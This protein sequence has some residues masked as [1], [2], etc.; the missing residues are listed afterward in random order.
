MTFDTC[1]PWFSSKITSQ[2]HFMLA[3]KSLRR[4]CWRLKANSW[5]HSRTCSRYARTPPI[6]LTCDWLDKL[7]QHYV[8]PL[9]EAISTQRP[10]VSETDVRSI[11][12]IVDMIY[13]INKN[14]LENIKNRLKNWSYE[15][16]IG[17]VFTSWVRTIPIIWINFLICKS[18]G[19]LFQSVSTVRKQLQWC[20]GYV[21][22]MR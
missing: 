22:Q 3:A 10:V 5:R 12:S 14:F 15:S 19:R 13:N 4:T 6:D 9:R 17:D 7:A 8:L 21:L 1:Q 18:I 11:F 16:V 2:G 20:C